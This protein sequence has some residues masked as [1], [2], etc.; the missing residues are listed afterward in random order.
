M[1][2]YLIEQLAKECGIKLQPHPIHFT[3]TDNPIDFPKP[4]NVELMNF[5]RMIIQQ[6]IDACLAERD[7]VGLNYSTN[8][9]YADAI[10]NKFEL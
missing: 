2:E 7:Q 6:C 10:K 4:V 9:K 3:N 8:V 1:K 5:A